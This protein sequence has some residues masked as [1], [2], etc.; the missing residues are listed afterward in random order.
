LTYPEFKNILPVLGVKT[1]DGAALFKFNHLD[2]NDVGTLN[3]E[4]FV[5][6]IFESI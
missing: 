1:S 5:K 6:L 3:Y 2:E 4:Q